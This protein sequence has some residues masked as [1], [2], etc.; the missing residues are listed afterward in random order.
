MLGL[1]WAPG[2]SLAAVGGCLLPAERALLPAA[3]SRCAAEDTGLAALRP[4][5]SSQTRGGACVRC[6][7]RRILVP[8]ATRDVHKYLLSSRNFPIY[9]PFKMS[10]AHV[11][12]VTRI[13]FLSIT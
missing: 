2:L 9:I 13:F 4:V 10:V 12:F 8:C 6:T 7:G 1:C 3:A 5:V 11:I